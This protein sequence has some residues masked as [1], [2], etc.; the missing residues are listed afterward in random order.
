MKNNEATISHYS[1]KIDP[2]PIPI[3]PEVI[4]DHHE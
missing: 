2:Y 4:S 1:R 3:L